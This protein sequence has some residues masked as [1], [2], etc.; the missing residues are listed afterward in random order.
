MIIRLRGILVLSL[1][2]RERFILGLDT[3]SVTGFSLKMY[4]SLLL[5]AIPA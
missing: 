5:Q 4:K 2:R 3:E 1:R